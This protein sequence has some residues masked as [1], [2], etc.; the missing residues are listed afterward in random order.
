MGTGVRAGVAVGVSVGV[1]TGMGVATGVGVA[2]GIGVATGVG[3]ATGSPGDVGVG[4]G[5]WQWGAMRSGKVS[6]GTSCPRTGPRSTQSGTGAH[7]TPGTHARGVGRGDAEN[8]EAESRGASA[9][10]VASA[11][12]ATI[13]LRPMWSKF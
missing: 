12:V 5:W 6:P 8:A 7:P 13:R 2:T 4:P 1:P 9:S 10:P 3:V 11:P